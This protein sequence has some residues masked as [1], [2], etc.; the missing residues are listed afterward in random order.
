MVDSLVSIPAAL[1]HQVRTDTGG[2][3]T[4]AGS[5]DTRA[6]DGSLDAS[7]LD[8]GAPRTEEGER[9]SIESDES[10]GAREQLDPSKGLLRILPRAPNA[11]GKGLKLD[12]LA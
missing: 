2:G 11:D 6:F 3:D 1:T 5:H 8:T 10:G 7:T 12:V 4:K 9:P